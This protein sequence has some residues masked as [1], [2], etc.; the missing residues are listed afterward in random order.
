MGVPA[1]MKS[2]FGFCERQRCRQRDNARCRWRKCCRRARAAPTS[3]TCAARWSCP[4]Q[5]AS[6]ADPAAWSGRSRAARRSG[7]RRTTGLIRVSLGRIASTRTD[8]PR[9]VAVAGRAAQLAVE[10]DAATVGQEDEVAHRATLGQRVLSLPRRR[11]VGRDTD[12][13]GVGGVGGDVPSRD[14]LVGLQVGAAAEDD[15][16]RPVL[17]GQRRSSTRRRTFA[18]VSGIMAVAAEPG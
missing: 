1:E 14:P 8:G 16:R 9:R 12:A 18:G 11:H 3:G 15:R 17:R 13:A 6:C 2:A 4:C 5:C 10:D 7:R